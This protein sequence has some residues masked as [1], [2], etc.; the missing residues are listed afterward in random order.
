MKIPIPIH[1]GFES[2]RVTGGMQTFLSAF[3]TKDYNWLFYDTVFLHS[4]IGV[5]FFKV[6]EL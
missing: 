2:P 4:T 5:T 6:M 3:V 1:S